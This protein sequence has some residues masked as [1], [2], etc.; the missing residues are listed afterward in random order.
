[1]RLL[2]SAPI[3]FLVVAS[4]CAPDPAAGW[5]SLAAGAREPRQ[6]QQLAQASAAREALFGGLLGELSAQLAAVG[7]AG[8]IGVCKEAAP[9]LAAEVG[10]AHGVRIGRTSE[11]LRNPGSKAPA[12]FPKVAADPGHATGPAT[13]V[14]EDGRL[15]VS[16][17][18]RVALPCLACHGTPADLGPGVS[19]ALARDYPHD[20]ATGYKLDD[21]R[22]WFWVEV[23]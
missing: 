4:A 10:A 17:P 11:R 19:D 2:R 23:P 21:L 12:W 18:I 6:T 15:G 13:A 1:M 9:R 22:G 14:H 5:R 3:A 8:A 7:P 16:F 20:R